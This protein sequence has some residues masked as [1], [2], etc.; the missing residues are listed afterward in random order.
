MQ[1][2][3]DCGHVFT[4]PGSKTEREKFEAWGAVFTHEFHYE[5]CPNCGGDDF[6][7]A[8]VC[9]L[10]DEPV[11]EKFD[12]CKYHLDAINSAMD[13]AVHTIEE[14]ADVGKKR[15]DVIQAIGYWLEER[16]G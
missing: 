14:S 6:E 13:A 8:T 3:N 5:C 9:G 4:E 1:I 2:C 16:E 12:Y 15:K 11:F 7:K 10:C